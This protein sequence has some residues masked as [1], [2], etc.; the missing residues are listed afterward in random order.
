MGNPGH[1]TLVAFGEQSLVILEQN[2]IL[3]E[4]QLLDQ[5]F[6]PVPDGHRVA[7][8]RR[9]NLLLAD[10]IVLDQI[11]DPIIETAD[12]MERALGMFAAPARAELFPRQASQLVEEKKLIMLKLGALPDFEEMCGDGEV[13]YARRLPQLENNRDSASGE[14]HA[15]H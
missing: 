5:R 6:D 14:G 9:Q 1:V 13:V 8:N 11:A 7:A 10:K 4:P 12:P 3:A 15:R 2:R